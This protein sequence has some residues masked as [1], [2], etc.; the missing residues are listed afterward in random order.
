MGAAGDGFG[1]LGTP[2]EAQGFSTPRSTGSGPIEMAESGVSGRSEADPHT[3]ARRP[4]HGATAQH[5]DV[6]VVDGLAAVRPRVDDEAVAVAEV[7]GAGDLA[8]GAQ[9]GPEQGGVLGQ[10]VGVG[11]DVAFG[12]DEH[13]DGGLGTDIGKGQR[14][15]RLMEALD[16][17]GSVDDFAEKAVGGGCLGHA[18]HGTRAIAAVR[19]S[20]ATGPAASSPP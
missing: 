20:H 6:E 7:L 2:G 1:F 16:G 19:V 17:N 9:Q 14:V 5:V 15:G 8:G 12:D 4:A 13:V 10:G 11:R 3:L 18:L